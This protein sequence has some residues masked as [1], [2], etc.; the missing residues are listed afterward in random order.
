MKK[1]RGFALNLQEGIEKMDR[2]KY[3][4]FDFDNRNADLEFIKLVKEATQ[5]FD[6]NELPKEMRNIYQQFR[7]NGFENV[8]QL[9]KIKSKNN[10]LSP[11]DLL[12]HCNLSIPTKI[13]EKIPKNKLE[14]YLPFNDFRFLP[15]DNKI[16][17]QCRG[18]KKIR[19]S[20]GN[21]YYYSYLRP[22]VEISKTKYIVAFSKH[23]IQRICE[24]INPVLMNYLALGDIY[25]YFEENMFFEIS[26]LA[27][28]SP[29]ITFWDLCGSKGFWH[30][31]YVQEV[32]GE[33]NLILG[34][35]KPYFR[36]GYCPIVFDGE[37]V[38]AKTLLFPGY[39]QTPEYEYI[40]NSSLSKFDKE[41]L[42]KKSTLQDA[43]SLFETG[44]FSTIQ[45][46]HTNTIPQVVQ[47]EGLIYDHY[48]TLPSTYQQSQ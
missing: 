45:W 14:K 38:I 16:I 35:G 15:K 8:I 43:K 32:L 40:I 11:Q 47:M 2:S 18:L 46:L 9:L 6:F 42:Q 27:D 34:K 13:F 29:A 24:R 1:Y 3:P 31:K 17:V 48:K 41:L 33:K 44:D 36:V 22:T 37:F 4:V 23:A 10:R 19:G 25:A 26:R 7:E 39:S 5:E 20:Q 30:Y 21:F 12:V 28:G